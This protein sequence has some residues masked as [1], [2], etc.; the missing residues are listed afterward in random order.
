MQ[1]ITLY[2]YARPGGGITVSPDRPD[3]ADYTVRYRLIADEGRTLANG[4]DTVDCVDVETPDGWT[5]IDAPPEEENT[6]ERIDMN[7]EEEEHNG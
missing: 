1:I 7:E 2:R 4:T 6:A 5:E 3:T